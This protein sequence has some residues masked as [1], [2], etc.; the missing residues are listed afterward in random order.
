MGDGLITFATVEE[1]AAGAR[2]IAADYGHHA[3]AARQLA[4]EHFDAE[5]VLERFLDEAL[6]S[7]LSE[8]RP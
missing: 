1:A 7:R 6:T 2:R 3:T 5:I 8:N 4:E